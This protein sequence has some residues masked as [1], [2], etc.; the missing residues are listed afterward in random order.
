MR[1]LGFLDK[2]PKLTGTVIA[3]VTVLGQIEELPQLLVEKVVDLVAFLVPRKWLGDIPESIRHCQ[4]Q[5][6]D[7][8]VAVDLF[9]HA[10]GRVRFI[11]KG[12]FP[13]LI[14]ESTSVDAWQGAT[15]R[16]IDIALSGTA[17]LILSPL[18]LLIAAAIKLSSPGPIFYS[19][20][21]SGLRGREFKMLK[22]RSM[23]M[24]A[25][26]LLEDLREKNEMAGAAFKMA[27]D[28]RI[29]PI[30]RLLRRFSLDELPQLI[31]ILKGDMSIVG[32][33][34]LIA[35]ENNKY[36]EWQ[37]RRMSVRP[38]LTCLWQINGRNKL[39]FEHWMELDLEYI[40]QWSLLMDLRIMVKTLPAVLQGRG[41]Y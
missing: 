17:L 3:G 35:T 38:G 22:F 18:F 25:D 40:D 21:R 11:T 4:I 9:D 14:M 29:T 15:K 16:A 31:N 37:R 20:V 32:P 10:N 30:G 34:P 13:L 36:E 33:R 39:D 5:G 23:V 6:V 12:K 7:V 26:D 28:P 24:H 1:V 2:D 19:Q 8:Q 41:A 27:N